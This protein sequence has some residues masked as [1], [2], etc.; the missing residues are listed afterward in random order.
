MKVATQKKS[1]DILKKAS[2]MNKYILITLI[3]FLFQQQAKAEWKWI[4]VFPD[5][6][7]LIYVPDKKENIKKTKP[8]SKFNYEECVRNW[9]VAVCQQLK[10]SVQK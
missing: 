4:Y 10:E 6:F 1:R 8:T 9:G 5:G 2:G 3:F 7:K